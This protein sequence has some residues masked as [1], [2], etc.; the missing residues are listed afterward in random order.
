MLAR[1]LLT[2]ATVGLVAL[3]GCSQAGLSVD[4]AYK[5]GC[6]A[7]DAAAASGSAVGKVV[8]SSLEQLR[9]SGSVTGESR[10]WLDVTVDFLANPEKVSDENKKMIRDGCA[11][12]GYKLQNFG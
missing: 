10:Q 9:D 11:A 5:V 6:P 7:L 2:G 1:S 4:D 8:L 12:H 3:S